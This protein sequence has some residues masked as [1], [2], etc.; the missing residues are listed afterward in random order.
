MKKVFY[1]Y[2]NIIC[3]KGVAD[4]YT[5][6]NEFE[7]FEDIPNKYIKPTIS[8]N[9]FIEGATQ[10]EIEVY[11]QQVQLQTLQQFQSKKEQDGKEYDQNTRLQITAS[12]YGRKAV[13]INEVVNQCTDFINP[14]LSLIKD[15][16]WYSVM[17][18]MQSLPEG[19]SNIEA[20]EW[21]DKIKTDVTAYVTQNYPR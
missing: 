18:K 4:D 12:F 2:Q 15:G 21:W 19:L 10:E 9:V 16:E 1:L 17:N 20:L 8:N 6:A 11:N 13:D 3:Y 14:M 7:T 5:L